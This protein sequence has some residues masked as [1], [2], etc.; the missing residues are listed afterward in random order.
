MTPIGA[1][2]DKIIKEALEGGYLNGRWKI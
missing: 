1:A 2:T